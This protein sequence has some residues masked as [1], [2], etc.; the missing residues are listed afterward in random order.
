[1]TVGANSG[2]DRSVPKGPANGVHLYRSAHL[3]RSGS[4]PGIVQAEVRHIGPLEGLDLHLP[5]VGR[6]NGANPSVTPTDREYRRS[7]RPLHAQ[8]EGLLALFATVPPQQ[9]DELQWQREIAALAGLCASVHKP[10]AGLA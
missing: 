5:V 9:V 1:M 8:A 7:L 2:L 10:F 4:V 6:V 3:G